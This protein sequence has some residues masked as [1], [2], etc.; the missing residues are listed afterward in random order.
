M[1]HPV[2]GPS[3]F[4]MEESRPLLPPG[5]FDPPDNDGRYQ[6]LFRAI[7][8]AVYFARAQFEPDGTC[9][10]V[11]YLDENPAAVRSRGGS[12]KGR[13]LSDLGRYEQDWRDIFGSVAR[14]GQSRRVRKYSA[15]DHRWYDFFVFK[16]EG[17][18]ADEF[19]VMYRDVTAAKRTEESLRQREGRHAFLVRL[20]DA[21]RET[22]D[23]AEIQAVACRLLGEQ[24]GASRVFYAEILDDGATALVRRDYVNGLPSIAGRHGVTLYGEGMIDP[25]KRGEHIVLDDAEH[26]RRLSPP[27]RAAFQALGV[28]SCMAA[29]LRRNGRWVAALS[30]QNASQRAWTLAESELLEETAER[31]WEAVERARAE[32]ELE[33]QLR[34]SNLLRELAVRMVGEEDAQKLYEEVLRTAITLMQADGGTVQILDEKT[35]ALV[36]IA[37]HG[38]SEEMIRFFARID[39]SSSTSCGRALASELR[40]CIDYDV[41]ESEDPDGSMR[42]HRAAGYLSAQSTPLVARS[43]RTIGMISTHWREHRRPSEHELRF[44][45]LLA[46]QAADLI[47]H[48]RSEEALRNTAAALSAANEQLAEADRRKDEFL[49]TLAHE[50]R[51]PLAPIRHAMTIARSSKASREQVARSLD[52][53]DGQVEHMA[54]LLDDLLDIARVT[55][56]K[57]VL[58]REAVEASTLVRSALESAGPLIE[59]RRHQVIV[60][61]APQGI[62]LDVD[63]MR[64]TQVLSNLLTNAAKYT[65]PGGTITVSATIERRRAVLRVRDNGMGISRSAM[66]HLFQ[67]FSQV[68][69]AVPRSGGGIGIGLALC[70]SLVEMHGGSINVSSE[71]IGHGTT[72]VIRLPLARSAQPSAGNEPDEDDEA[73][74]ASRRVL[75]VDDNKE[76]VELLETLLQLEGHEV[77]IAHSGREALRVADLFVPEVVVLDIGMPDIDGHEVARVLRTRPWGRAV[78]L[79]ALS[80]WGHGR[81]KA[82]SAEAGIDYHLTKPAESG[83]IMRLVGQAPRFLASE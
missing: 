61:V 77:R 8:E 63:P 20:A 80:G 6:S 7:D 71:G 13:R 37:S 43:G 23:A 32:R 28:A 48:R 16:P 42:M 69:T 10:D 52:V 4:A 12:I 30:V 31:T 27:A 44:V 57:L 72:F 17:A 62:A 3:A 25:L 14:T 46:R 1:G 38:M 75:V 67:M 51:N 60:D 83:E 35:P 74:P 34:D 5:G 49:G 39:A 73:V 79:V 68:E 2:E 76:A 50:L 26:D 41:P 24:L 29:G 65:D 58:R 47:E 9:V 40:V 70:K 53:V 59:E 82:R 45:D 19:A 11:L 64:I 36:L 56:G 15:P 33:E 21:M 78:T 66:P 54:L 18:D 22:G 81:D 55:Q